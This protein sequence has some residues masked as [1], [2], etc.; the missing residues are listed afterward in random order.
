MHWGGKIHNKVLLYFVRV[1]VITALSYFIVYAITYYYRNSGD[2]RAILVEVVMQE[3]GIVPLVSRSSSLYLPLSYGIPVL[4]APYALITSIT[5]VMECDADDS[6][7]TQ[8]I[9]QHMWILGCV[10]FIV[11]I[12]AGLKM[13]EII[14]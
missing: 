13:G 6:E 7:L 11:L 9:L 2:L 1:F 3:V 10:L 14:N 12:L 8:R 5:A 4:P